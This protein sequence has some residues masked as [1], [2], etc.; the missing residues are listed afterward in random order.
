MMQTRK[1]KVM[2]R[3]LP[4]DA[5]WREERDIEIPA[6]VK[7]S[8]FDAVKTCFPEHDFNCFAIDG[9]RA[10]SGDELLPDGDC[11]ICCWCVP[12]SMAAIGGFLLKMGAAFIAG[13]VIG[14]LVSTLLSKKTKQKYAKQVMDVSDE[15][16]GWDYDARNAVTEGAPIPVLYGRR[17]VLPPTIMHHVETDN[18]VSESYLSNIYAVCEGGGGFNDTIMFPAGSDGNIQAKINHAEWTSFLSDPTSGEADDKTNLLDGADVYVNFNPNTH[19]GAVTNVL[20]NGVFEAEKS[21][22]SSTGNFGFS[23]GTSYRPCRVYFYSFRHPGTSSGSSFAYVG[24]KS[25]SLYGLYSGEWRLIGTSGTAA[26]KSENIYMCSLDISASS[27]RIRYSSYYIEPTYWYG[28]TNKRQWTP[29]EIEFYGVASDA[30]DTLG[31]YASVSANSG[32]YEQQASTQLLQGTWASLSVQKRLDLNWFAYKTTPGGYPDKVNLQLSFPYGLYSQSSGSMST[33]EVSVSVQ[34]RAVNEDGTTGE[35]ETLASAGDSLTIADSS[36]SEKKYTIADTWST[37]PYQAEYRMKF[38]ENPNPLAGEVCDCVW[39]GLDEGWN[40][41][42]IYPCTATA[43]LKMFATQNISGGDPQFKILAE[44]PIV[45]IYNSISGTWE[46]RSASNPAWAAY[47]L[48]VRPKFDDRTEGTIPNESTL[49]REAYPHDCIVYTDFLRWANFC[50]SHKISCSMYYDGTTTVKDAVAMLCELGRAA[51]VNR[52]A[53]LGVFIDKAWE[54]TLQDGTPIPVYEF[55]E[56]NIVAETWKCS[57]EN[58]NNLPT[59][60]NVTFYDSRREWE[61]FTV[62]ARDSARDVE[63]REQ[64]ISDITLYAC[65][66]RETAEA[67]A[68]YILSQNLVRRTFEWSASIDAMPLDV[69][70]VVKLYDDY[71]IVTSIST[72]GELHRAFTA[73]EYA[74]ER[75]A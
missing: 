9:A 23:F 42:C 31:G 20:T 38:T 21:W 12:E 45:N 59:Q 30:A 18:V 55:N 14:G 1:I 13:M 65:D 49:L 68:D 73:M 69:G 8:I 39:E 44:R 67:H 60:V 7:T 66:N 16:Y 50:D 35:W 75:Y 48:I 11:V 52:G 53:R 58:P 19:E 22:S 33:K 4:F 47:D 25:F 10:D 36:T 54:N 43:T 34:R 15:Q 63:S 72:D 56:D 28:N 26:Q 32:N 71:V 40:F 64:N 62:I 17:L 46:E 24:V 74:P 57:Y 51:I 27:E 41:D 2:A 3:Q 29:T 6:N 37:P 5:N 70:D 61:R